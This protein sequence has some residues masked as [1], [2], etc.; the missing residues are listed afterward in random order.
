MKKL[1]LSILM[2]A[3]LGFAYAGNDDTKDSKSSTAIVTTI[4]VTGKIIDFNTGETLTGVEVKIEGTQLKAYSDFDGN[5]FFENVNPGKYNIIA[6]FISYKKSLVED[7][8]ADGN[9]S[10][11]IK[12][13][14]D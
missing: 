7:Y 10:I 4:S 6:S 1:V 9:S 2:I 8:N 3:F 14:A 12:L 5:F 11:E 13:Q